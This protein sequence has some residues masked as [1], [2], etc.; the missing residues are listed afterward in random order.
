MKIKNLL[1]VVAHLDDLEM[2]AAGTIM[3][4]QKENVN[5]H[6]LILTESAWTSETGI[7]V[8]SKEEVEKEMQQVMSYMKYTTCET[9]NE[10]TLELNHSDKLVTEVLYR[11]QKYKID[12]IITS[13]NKDSH[14]DHRIAYE[15]ALSA[16]RRVPNF[17]MGQINYYMVELFTPNFYFDISAEWESKLKCMSMFSSQWDRNKKDWTEF[18]DTTSRYYGKI[19]GT[20]RAEG[21]I[22]LRGKY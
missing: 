18:L 22:L 6:V 20:E 13:W 14:R 5:I 16:S 15:I 17:L 11:V 8:R 4:L 19:I 1:A 7:V 10:K 12:T 3:R 9:L 21:F 2:M